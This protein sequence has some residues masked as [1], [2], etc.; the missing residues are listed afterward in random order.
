MKYNENIGS[1]N[2]SEK[3]ISIV[4]QG[5]VVPQT[6]KYMLKARQVFPDAEIIL[7]T[8]IGSDVQGLMY[9]KLILNEDPGANARQFYYQDFSTR[10]NQN[11]Q[12]ISTING[13]RVATRRYAIKIRTDF[14]IENKDFILKYYKKFN[15]RNDNYKIFQQRVIIPSVF[16]RLFSNETHMPTPFHPSDWF[17]FGLTEDLKTFYGSVGQITKE[18]AGEWECRFPNHVPYPKL[19]WRYAPEQFFFYS[20]VK[21]K[22]TNLKFKDWSDFNSF[23]IYLSKE[24]IIDNF[25]V[26]D[27]DQIGLISE[28][29]KSNLGL[30]KIPLPG[31]LTYDIYKKMYSD[32][33]GVVERDDDLRENVNE[34]RAKIEEKKERKEYEKERIRKHIY[35]F[36]SPV[37]CFLKWVGEPFRI[38]WHILKFT[39]VSVMRDK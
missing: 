3:D 11:R 2:I 34:P 37:R 1:D 14:G 15:L 32:R 13:L 25:I 4:F 5:Q 19:R 7:S 36:Y 29:H 6:K 9:D 22:F 10:N 33:Y 28:K 8:W 20:A 38:L 39:K 16:T 35:R 30:P 21:R 18:E 24:L 27:P 23:N 17:S 31:L 12:F 26:L